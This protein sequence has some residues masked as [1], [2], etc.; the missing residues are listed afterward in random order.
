MIASPASSSPTRYEAQPRSSLRN[1]LNS[2][3]ALSRG[4]RP[5]AL[6]TVARP[7]LPTVIR[8]MGCRK[9]PARLAALGLVAGASAALGGCGGNAS[10]QLPTV[11]AATGILKPPP[12]RALVQ[13]KQSGKLA[14]GLAATRRG[15]R[16]ALVAS[17]LTPTGAR[18]GLAV[19]FR[20]GG[21]TV[22]ATPCGSGCYSA[23]TVPSPTVTVVV[24]RR[25]SNEATFELPA[26]LPAPSAAALVARATAVF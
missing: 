20:T 6:S 18:G 14:V 24:G 1:C 11:P 3:A 26:R 15:G 16:N 21:K 4:G 22:P 9:I 17:V 10:P 19:S 23:V 7:R 12:A 13:G 5:N 2:T 8:R 25:P